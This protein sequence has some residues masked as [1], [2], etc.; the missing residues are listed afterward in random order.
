MKSK[1]LLAVVL[2]LP[3]SSAAKADEVECQPGQAKVSFADGNS[4]SSVCVDSSDMEESAVNTEIPVGID[5][6][7]TDGRATE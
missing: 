1:L 7:N 3:L 5:P 2:G 6:T 4:L